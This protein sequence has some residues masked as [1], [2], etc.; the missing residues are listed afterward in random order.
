LTT[1]TVFDEEMKAVANL[2]PMA[3]DDIEAISSPNTLQYFIRDGE[4]LWYH[5]PGRDTIYMVDGLKFA[6]RYALNF[7]RHSLTR[8]DAN[9]LRSYDTHGRGIQSIMSNNLIHPRS[10]RFF[11]LGNYFM[12]SPTIGRLGHT[13]FYNRE[14]GQMLR[15]RQGEP[16][17]GIRPGSLYSQDDMIF[18]IVQATTVFRA[19]ESVEQ[20]SY[21]SENKESQPF[22]PYHFDGLQRVDRDDNAILIIF[23]LVE[24]FLK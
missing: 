5:F 20:G 16:Y 19:R 18:G 7:G 13:F 8:S 17:V 24:G 23:N 22:S 10:V 21:P 11:S 4:N 14:N 15:I 9:D 1:I 2:F 6:P 3:Y 12:I